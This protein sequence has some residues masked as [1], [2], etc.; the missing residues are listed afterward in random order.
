MKR[1][2]LI[3]LASFFITMSC[4]VDDKSDDISNENIISLWHLVNTTG[5]ISGANDQFSLGI[6]IWTFDEENGTLTI[7]NNNSD[8]AKEDSL[9]SGTYNY[10]ITE[11]DTTSFIIVD[12]I[13]MGELSFTSNNFFEINQNETSTG[14]AA[15][16][17]IYTFQRTFV[18]VEE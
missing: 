13:E 2:I 6:V 9:D 8:G 16:G 17:Y 11:T 10:S 5:G 14:P 4:S 3:L 12:G 18:N 7:E 15:D 1:Y